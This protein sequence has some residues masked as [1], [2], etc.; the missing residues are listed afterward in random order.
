MDDVLK[1]L[2]SNSLVNVFV[3]RFEQL[4]LS[5]QL[6]AGQRLPSE[7]ELALR[8]GVSRPVVHEGLIDLQARDLIT[9]MPRKG[10]YVNDF[11]TKGSLSVLQSLFSYNNGALS[12][13]ILESL[14]R[15]R[16]LIE[17]ETARLA[18]GQR[19]GDHMRQFHD[20]LAGE[21]GLDVSDITA[22]AEID[23]EFHLLIA[24]ASGNL[25]YPL[26]MNSFKEVYINLSGQFFHN[27][28][29]RARV[30]AFHRELANA[31][32][33]KDAETAVSIMKQLLVHGEEFL[34]REIL[35]QE[36]EKDTERAV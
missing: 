1:P 7:R 28:A 15:M 16:E 5:G 31:I 8:L 2:Q 30:H 25:I 12:P 36:S 29:V 6:T 18:A 9:L 3:E 33:G 13:P 20:I 32:N 21:E 35:K 11:R 10:A 17:L 22:L 14:L 26:L 27:I 4:I 23:F 19:T 34:K 24:M